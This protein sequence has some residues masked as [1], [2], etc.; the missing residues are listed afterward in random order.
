MR[1]PGFYPDIP[2]RDYHADRTTLSQSG[3]KV[4][5][6]SP[7]QFRW[8]Q[9]NPKPPSDAMLIGT[10]THTEILGV[11]Q[12]WVEIP[13]AASRKQADQDAYKKAVADAEAA[14]LIVLDPDRAERLR[15]M[16]QAVL[17]H[18]LAGPLFSDGA[19]EVTA[20]AEDDET[21]IKRRARFDWLRDDR[22]GVDL[23]TSSYPLPADFAKAVANRGYHQ[24]NAWYLDVAADLGHPLRSLI[25]VVVGSSPPHHVRVYELDAESIAR[26]RDLNERAL[27][28]YRR[29]TDSGDWSEPSRITPLSLPAWAFRDDYL[30]ETA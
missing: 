13:K 15:G 14:D 26:G 12:G 11:G 8:E 17:A 6:E 19:G 21:G 1:E 22:L 23:K 2:E 24:Q 16:T 25:F 30:E 9:D 29:C 4:L 28:V 20:Y 10:A 5:L 27:R 3:A 7:A 18:P